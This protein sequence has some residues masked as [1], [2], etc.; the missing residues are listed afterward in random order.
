MHQAV[1]YER[2]TE[3]RVRCHICQWHCTINPAKTGVCRVY[4]NRNGVLYSLNYA[5][6]SSV[7]VDPIEKKPLFHFFPGTKAL[8][9]GSWGC[10]FHCR[11]CQNW[12]IACDETH[13]DAWGQEILPA[14]AVRL[15]QENGCAGIAWTYNEPSMWFEYTLD[16]AR[17]AK[18]NGLYTAYV[19]NGYLSPGTM[20]VIG[21]YLDAWRV[22]IKGFSD[23]LYH[24]LTGITQW[25]GI[26]E[27]AVRARH[28]WGMH[29]EVITNIIPGM[30]DD[31][32]QLTELARWIRDELGKLTP[33]HVTRFFPNYHL[34]DIS[35]TPIEIL[36]KAYQIG[37]DA[38]LKF[39]YIGN[40]AD[41][42]SETTVCYSCGR[43]VV[44]R[45]GYQAKVV[46][47]NGTHC[48]HCGT[49]LNFRGVAA[50]GGDG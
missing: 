21:P 3:S 46:G 17:L 2:L 25:R 43:P 30:N 31:D 10:N 42:D 40:V 34:Q 15:A 49:D 8:S 35:P 16:S 5:R 38:G 47:L 41:D 29:I 13:R 32:T 23:D 7:A 27:A 26:L 11:D 39:V 6:A 19:T 14:A 22:D 20:D 44:R 9:L 36:K 37:R 18:D 45:R 48:R 1:L 50:S 12:E 4:Q 28:R 24:N 33:W